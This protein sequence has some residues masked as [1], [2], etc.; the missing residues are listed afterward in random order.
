MNDIQILDI[1][2]IFV[3]IFL[4]VL[5]YNAILGDAKTRLFR[6]VWSSEKLRHS[7]PHMARSQSDAISSLVQMYAIQRRD[8]KLAFALSTTQLIA[9]AITFD[10]NNP[11]NGG[12][13]VAPVLARE[14]AARYPY[15]D[16]DLAA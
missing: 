8:N 6:R 7:T 5:A 16:D 15:P 11:H 1:I 13:E 12:V 4:A 9:D 14:M 2:G 10:L 3:V